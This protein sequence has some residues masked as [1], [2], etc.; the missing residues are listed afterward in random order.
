MIQIM[1]EIS[2]VKSVVVSDITDD[3]GDNIIIYFTHMYCDVQIP[4]PSLSIR[5]Q[6]FFLK[7]ITKLVNYH[8]YHL[9]YKIF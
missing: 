3:Y 1:L 6:F 7:N 2:D 8:N 9:K 5:L 4:I